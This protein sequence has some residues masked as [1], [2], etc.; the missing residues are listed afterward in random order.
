MDRDGLGAPAEGRADRAA[1]LGREGRQWTRRVFGRQEPIAPDEP[2]LHVSWY[3]ADAYARWAGRRL[4]TEAEWEKAARFDPA[5][6][7]TRRYP[8]GNADPDTSYA[9]V[10][11][12]FLRPAPAG[13]YPEGAAP[14]G[15]RQLIGDVWEWTSSDFLPYPGFEAWPYKEYSEVFFGP[16]YKVLR[17]GSFAVT[18]C[19]PG[20]VPQLGLP[21]QAADLRRLPYRQVRRAGDRLMCRHLAY[22]GPPASLRSVL[23]DPPHG[24]YRQA[25]APRRQGHGTMNADG[26]GVGWYAGRDPDPARYRRGGP[27]LGVTRPAPTSPGSP[28]RARCSRRSGPPRREPRPAAAAAPSASAGG[29]SATT[30]RSTAGRRPP[31]HSPRRCRPRAARTEARVDSALLWALALPASARRAALAEAF[32][33][34]AEALCAEGVTGRF[35]FLLTDG[36]VIAATTAGHTLYYRQEP[37]GVTV[38]SEPG[39][40][41]ADWSEIPRD[42]SL[43][44]RHARQVSVTRLPARTPSPRASR[45]PDETPVSPD[46]RDPRMEGSRSDDLIDRRLPPGFLAESLRADARR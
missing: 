15:A 40:D 20:H 27:D 45:P 13:A 31:R 3:E 8:W 25:W 32:G 29:C 36:Q 18:R 28:G 23:I 17:G 46:A 37:G 9:N 5:T 2:V 39:D 44:D 43:V 4:P 19:V 10:G 1:V 6:G 30:A 35:N 7:L 38:A 26:F 42:G 41:E 22:L 12:A 33:D 24:L 21:D 14:C 11:Q 16:E 34:T